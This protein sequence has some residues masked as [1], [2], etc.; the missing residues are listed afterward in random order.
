VAGLRACIGDR[1]IECEMRDDD[2]GGAV[3]SSGVAA[4]AAAAHSSYGSGGAAAQGSLCVSVGASWA[5][6]GFTESARLAMR[7]TE[8]RHSRDRRNSF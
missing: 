2:D 5:S 1:L 6:A 3:I 7:V 8:P 4:E